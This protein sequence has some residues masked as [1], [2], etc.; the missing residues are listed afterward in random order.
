VH[1]RGGIRPE[2]AVDILRRI[3][4]FGDFPSFLSLA[5]DRLSCWPNSPI[6]PWEGS[7]PMSETMSRLPELPDAEFDATGAL[8]GLL[9]H[10]GLSAADAGG[11]MMFAGHDPIIPARHRL[12]AAIGIP[13]M[14]NAVAAAAMHRHRGGPA[15]DLHLDLRQAVHH[16]NPSYGWYPETRLCVATVG[17]GAA[18]LFVTMQLHKLSTLDAVIHRLLDEFPGAAVLDT[19][20]VLRS[21][22]S[23]GRLLGPDRHAQ[24]IVPVDLWAP[25]RPQQIDMVGRA[26]S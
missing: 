9:A 3:P 10:V 4:H 11:R 15:Q 7:S 22:K 1:A 6:E 18:N 2:D 17:S 24:A 12:A 21:V 5:R 16:I 19:R 25:A 26:N 20:V 14:G 23:W 13:M 8:D